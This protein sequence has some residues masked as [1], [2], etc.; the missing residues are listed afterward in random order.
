MEVFKE[1]K[2]P[3]PFVLSKEFTASLSDKGNLRPVLEARRWKSFTEEE[4][5]GF[6]ITQVVGKPCMIQVIHNENW[7][8]NIANVSSVPKGMEC[9]A[10]INPTTIF[11][12]WEF[13]LEVF[14]WLHDFIKDKIKQSKEYKELEWKYGE[15]M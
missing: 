11:T 7:Y 1:E 3:E 6:D 9:P 14:E 8:A 12:F 4:L 10:Q 15:I 2:W 13:D 5:K